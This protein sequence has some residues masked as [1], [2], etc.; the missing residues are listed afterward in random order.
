MELHYVI[1]L[2]MFWPATLASEMLYSFRNMLAW[3]R[4]EYSQGLIDIF[5]I[6]GR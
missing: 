4:L 1:E 5:N 3:Q 2:G 6:T